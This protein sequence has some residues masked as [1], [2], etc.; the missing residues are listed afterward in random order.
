MN[1]ECEKENVRHGE[2]MG[3]CVNVNVNGLMLVCL[4]V[5][6]AVA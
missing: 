3:L 5:C 1:V 4:C 6:G 2:V